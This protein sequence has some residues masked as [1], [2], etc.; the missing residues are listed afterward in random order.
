M[1]LFL[2]VLFVA[3]GMALALGAFAIGGLTALLTGTAVMFTLVAATV[4]LTEITARRLQ[5]TPA[6]A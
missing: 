5:T 2:F 4:A 1:P 3:L 6:K